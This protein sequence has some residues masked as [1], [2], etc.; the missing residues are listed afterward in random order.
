MSS[1]ITITKLPAMQVLISG[2]SPT[3]VDVSSVGIPGPTGPQGIQ[4][5]IGPA[6]ELT[7]GT[8]DSGETAAA[9]ITGSAPSQTLNLT[10]PIGPQGEQGPQVLS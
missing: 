1:V 2:G 6:N 7:V 10:L 9:S 4:G 3:V 5:E 8:V